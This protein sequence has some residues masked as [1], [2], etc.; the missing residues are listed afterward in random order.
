M[1]KLQRDS[2]SYS[3]LC[4]II[5]VV[6]SSCIATAAPVKTNKIHL[7]GQRARTLISL[8]VSGSDRI[9]KAI[10]NSDE[11]RVILLNVEVESIETYKYETDSWIYKLPGYRASGKIGT[12]DNQ[13]SIGEATSLFS[14]FLKVGVTS[15]L[16]MD[17][18]YITFQEISCKIDVHANITAPE[19]FQCDLTL[20]K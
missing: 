13:I 14:F 19:R 20:P 10:G 15:E 18:S 3:F 7:N 8:L 11:H 4:F 2:A 1:T 16:A 17:G 9:S 12:D 6:L 5:A